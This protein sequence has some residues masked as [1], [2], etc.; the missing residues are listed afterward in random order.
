MALSLIFC[1]NDFCF[2]TNLQHNFSEKKN[3]ELHYAT[4]PEMWMTDV[5]NVVAR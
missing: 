2:Q 5:N 3:D 1:N 4:S